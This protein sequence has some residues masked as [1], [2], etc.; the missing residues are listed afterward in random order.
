MFSSAVLALLAGASAVLASSSGISVSLTGKKGI[1]DVDDFKVV[2]KITN[3]GTET[4]TLLNDPNTLLTPNWATK[5]FHLS[6]AEGV[7]PEFKGVAVGHSALSSPL[8][9]MIIYALTKLGQVVGYRSYQEQGVH[10]PRTWTDPETRAHPR[11]RL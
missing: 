7:V 5:T 6:N 10:H 9:S 3:S 2:A 11:W 1:A 4:I 8:Y